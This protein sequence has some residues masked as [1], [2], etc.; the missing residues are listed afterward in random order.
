M[1]IRQ[2]NRLN[3]FHVTVHVLWRACLLLVL[4]ALTVPAGVVAQS[5]DAEVEIGSLAALLI[6]TGNEEPIYVVVAFDESDMNAVD[7]LRATDLSVVTVEF[8]GL[9]EGVCKIIE[10]GCDVSDCRRRLC[11]TGD[12]ESPFWQFW[13]QDDEGQWSLSARGASQS[14]IEN[15]DI[16]AWSWTGV[17]PDLAPL[18]WSGIARL[19]GA[20]DEIAGGE[21]AA[22]PEVWMTPEPTGSGDSNP[23]L[24]NMLLSS[25]V[26]VLIAVAGM[27]L[28]RRQ[29]SR[30]PETELRDS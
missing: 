28:A 22:R 30:K 18:E 2:L 16:V 20:P 27:V 9:G 17:E 3:P 14:M 1:P 15:G 21:R 11:Q 12:P 4:V 7:L 13:R 19:A 29:Q 5:P 10:T 26:L 25:A 24:T 6:D 23:S 8:G